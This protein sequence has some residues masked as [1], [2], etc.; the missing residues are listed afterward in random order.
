VFISGRSMSNNIDIASK[1]GYLK[2]PAGLVFD[3]KKYQEQTPD[4]NTLILTTGSQGESVS[5]MTRIA[6]NEHPHIR[7]KKGDTIVFSSSPI[8]GNERAIYTVINNLALMGAEVIHDRMMDVHASGHAK[9]DELEKMIS[10]VKPKYL[11]PIHGEYYM[12]QSLGRLGVQR[13]G[14]PESNVIMI[15]NGDVLLV[16]RQGIQKSKEVIETKYILIDGRGEG[17]LG[18]QVQYDREMMSQNGAVIVLVHINKKTKKLSKTPDVVSRGF[19]YMHESEEIT[20][21]ICDLAG[22]AYKRITSKR[23]DIPRKEIKM[24][25]KQT[26]DKYTR[27]KLERRPLIIPLIIEG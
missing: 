9:Q 26:I 1:L 6:S 14:I 18:S 5:A 27:Q 10:L 7:V 2:Y 3:I 19:I 4:K 21:E 11:I 16:D 12:R 20:Q 15:Q 13:C 8:I 23:G 25:I 24:F 22:E 17:T